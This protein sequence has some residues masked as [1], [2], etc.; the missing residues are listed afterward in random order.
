MTPEDLR[1][2]S[3]SYVEA[4]VLLCA[5]ELR[6][7]DH[8][9]APAEEVANEVGGT[10]RGVEILLDAL[11][12]MDVLHKSAGQYSLEP[13][14]RDDLLSSGSTHFVS[15][16]RHRNR[17][18]RR[19]A[20]L[21][22]IIT[23]RPLP[24][25]VDGPG[26]LADPAATGDFIRAMFAVSSDRAAEVAAVLPLAGAKVIADLGG[27]PGHY[28]LAML[29]RAPEARGILADLPISLEV[30]R[31]LLA[32]HRLEGRIETVA[33]DL[34]QGEPSRAIPPIDL[35]FI[36]QVLHGRG[37]EANRELLR[38]VATHLAPDGRLVIHENVVDEDRCK[39]RQAALFA[40][41]MLAM[42]EQGRT[43]TEGEFVAWGEQ[44]GLAHDGS[45]RLDE[46]SFLV[47][48]RRC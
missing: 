31:E 48:L 23:G 30:A 29:A 21:E 36:S 7:F 35:A 33:W 47:V 5:A 46:R 11:V 44:A 26:L 39:P 22:E 43:Y 9:P 40:V 18:F 19:W 41:N 27:G 17:L 3:R 10:L 15:L 28:L 38:R 25:A 12:A 20:F 16:L 24:S 6:V 45:R 34:Y 37:P 1:T 32:G 2:I 42:T 13:A 14:L 4:K 8:L